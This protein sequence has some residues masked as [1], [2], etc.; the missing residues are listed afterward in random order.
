MAGCGGEL[1]LVG[2][3][4]SPFMVRVQIALRLKG[5]SYEYVEEDLQ[6][7][8]ELLLRSNPVHLFKVRS[9]ALSGETGQEKEERRKKAAAAVETLEG[10][11]RESKARFFSGRDGPG[12]VDIMLGGLLGS[13]R[14][15][16]EMHGWAPDLGPDHHPAAGRMG[17]ALLHAG[18]GGAG[19]AARPE[20]RRVCRGDAATSHR[21]LRADELSVC[22]CIRK[23]ILF[24]NLKMFT[25]LEK[26]AGISK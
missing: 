20:A 5:L 24:K 15:T 13:M 22:A 8:S 1:K 18:R 10:V 6:N 4:A 17:G 26:S 21:Q 19:H 9:Q 3:W 25:F 7:K 2:M 11:L 16:E 23:K 12:Y 14:A